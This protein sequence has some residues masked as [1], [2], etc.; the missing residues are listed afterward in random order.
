MKTLITII[1]NLLVLLDLFAQESS[2][3]NYLEMRTPL[4]EQLYAESKQLKQNGTVEQ[5]KA[6]RL[7]IKNAWADVDPAIADLYKPLPKNFG[8]QEPMPFPVYSEHSSPNSQTPEWGNDILIWDDWVDGVDMEVAYNGDIYIA[9]LYSDGI[10]N[11]GDEDIIRIYRST[12]NGQ[13]FFLVYIFGVF[14]VYEK[15]EMQLFTSVISTDFLTITTL[16]ESNFLQVNRY[17][18]SNGSFDFTTIGGGIQNF[19]V[20]QTTG[21]THAQQL[22][23]LYNKTSDGDT[24]SAR[25]SVGSYGFDWIDEVNMGN[26]MGNSG[27]DI[28]YGFLGATYA[29]MINDIWGDI[30]GR[31][32]DDDAD[33]TSWTSIENIEDGLVTESANPRIIATRNTINNDNVL[34][35]CSS[36]PV[37][38]TD[39]Y[40]GAYYK[41]ENGNDY[42]A[43]QIYLSPDPDDWTVGPFDVYRGRALASSN[44]LHVSA[45]LNEISGSGDDAIVYR[46]YDGDDFGPF[47]NMNDDDVIDDFYGAIAET[48]D[49]HICSA[50]AGGTGRGHTLYYDAE[51]NTVGLE[52]TLEQQGY[53]LSQNHPNPVSNETTFRFSLPK[54]TEVS[55]TVRDITGRQIDQLVNAFKSQGDHIIHWQANVAPG[56]YFYSMHIDGEQITRKM[57]VQ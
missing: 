30:H 49:R 13:S 33:P 15:F 21:G 14:A 45:V 11:G 27:M 8:D 22:L 17:N 12:D 37:G 19:A 28:D 7:A 48:I 53:T 51:N 34:I 23:V 47:N 54:S 44:T 4:L 25:S 42:G 20:T 6:N 57:I 41:R 39:G 5:L 10:P 52:E 16:S 32:N 56:I 50:F 40:H 2:S 29:V 38:S 24:Y 9:F 46:T 3:P 36:R 1:L 26:M 31:A 18:L 35:V 55:L 43:K